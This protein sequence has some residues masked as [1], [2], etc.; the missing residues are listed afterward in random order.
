MVEHDAGAEGPGVERLDL[1]DCHARPRR[2]VSQ[3]LG[4]HGHGSANDEG[5]GAGEQFHKLILMTRRESERLQQ[6]VWMR[7][8]R[9]CVAMLDLVLDKNVK[10]HRVC[11]VTIGVAK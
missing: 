6:R 5:L 8:I 11:D 3:A 9:A 4:I 7:A 1:Q 2:H 10:I